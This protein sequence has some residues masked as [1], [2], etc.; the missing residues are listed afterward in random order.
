MNLVDIPSPDVK[1]LISE[2]L[3]FL[4]IGSVEQHG[5]HLP[6]DVDTVLPFHICKRLAKETNGVI[7][8]PIPYGAR[9]LPMSGGGDAFPGTIIIP[10]E[11]LI[12]YYKAVI[13]GLVLNGAVNLVIINGHFENEPFIF[14]AIDQ[15]RV[16]GYFNQNFRLM[17]LSWWSVV[18]D[19]FMRK[20]FGRFDG[21]HCEHAAQ[22]ETALMLYFDPNRVNMIR[23]EDHTKPIPCGLYEYPL[24]SDLQTSHGVLSP[25]RHATKE[26]GEA[27]ADF[28]NQQ[29]YIRLKH[30]GLIVKAN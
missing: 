19:Q 13:Q 14:E 9:S 25:C 26:M 18:S 21:W 29:L 20:I 28:I 11:V 7:A 23:A 22:A 30:L 16:E 27:L 15:L 2:K 5:H 6:L 17:A 8:P 12:S 3:V 10:G 1:T 24:S 4:P